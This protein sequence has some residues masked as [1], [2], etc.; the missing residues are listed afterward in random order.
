[1]TIATWK[2][3]LKP[4]KGGKPCRQNYYANG[5]PIRESTG[6]E[7]EKEAERFLKAREGRVVTGQPIPPRADRVSYDEAAAD[8]RQHYLAHGTRNLKE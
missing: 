3:R 6:T 7:K 2:R 8:L 1:M 5:R 4:G